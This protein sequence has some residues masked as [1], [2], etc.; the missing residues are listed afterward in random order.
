MDRLL[1]SLPIIFCA[2]VL[3]SGVFF[4]YQRYRGSELSRIPEAPPLAISSGPE[5]TSEGTPIGQ[6]ESTA[7]AT[8]ELAIY[9]DSKPGMRT[10]FDLWRFYGKGS[11]SFGSPDLNMRFE[12]WREFHQKQ[13]S[14]LM[15]DV[16]KY[17]RKRFVFSGQAISGQ[18][19]SGGKKPV[20]KIIVFV[21]TPHEIRKVTF[22]I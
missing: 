3:V 19:M 5:A 15:A 17:M 21:I 6:N 20:M 7:S 22:M 11:S 4:T 8:D 13:K 14:E 1:K 12:Q 2:L 10:P 9:P 16:Q 18:F